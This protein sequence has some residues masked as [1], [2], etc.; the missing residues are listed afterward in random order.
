[1][2][3]D[4]DHCPLLLDADD[5]EAAD[6][7]DGYDDDHDAADVGDDADADGYADDDD[8]SDVVQQL[9]RL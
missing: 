9:S 7:G 5:D 3:G 2:L 1:M 6:D 8:G 4:D